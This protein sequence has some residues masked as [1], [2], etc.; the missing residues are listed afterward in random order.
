MKE[1]PIDFWNERCRNKEYIYG[2]EPNEFFSKQLG[3]LKISKAGID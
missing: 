1:R 3:E 2:T